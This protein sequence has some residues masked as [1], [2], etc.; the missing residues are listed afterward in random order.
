MPEMMLLCAKCN[1]VLEGDFE[2]ITEIRRTTFHRHTDT[3]KDEASETTHV[4]D[5]TVA[6]LKIEPCKRC[7]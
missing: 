7:P 4:G 2:T 3:E 1:K 6:I 5:V